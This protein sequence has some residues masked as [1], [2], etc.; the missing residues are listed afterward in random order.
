MARRASGMCSHRSRGQRVHRHDICRS[1]RANAS[2]PA[3][4]RIAAKFIEARTQG[5]SKPMRIAQIAP[6]HEAVPP[7]L[8][9]GTERVVSYP[10]RGAGG[11]RPRRDAVRQ[12]RFR[13]LRPACEPVW[14]RALRLD[15]AIRDPIAPHMLLMEAVRRQADDFD[16]LHFHM[17][18]W[19]FSPVQPPAHAVR[20]HAARPARP[21]GAAAGVRHLPATCRWCRSRN[22]QRRP[23]PQAQL[24][25]HRASRPAGGPADAAA[26]EPRAISPSSAASRRRRARTAPSA[27][28]APAASRSRSRPRWTRSTRTISR[29]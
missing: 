27:S 1:R 21:A 13:H 7:K 16:V 3:S 4:C 14:P 25:R 29:R 6:L 18:Y 26:G 8:Y 15:P 24:R 22:A 12:R 17:D 2:I 5:D 28:P 20:D 23:L 19:P 9:G 11:A 10:D